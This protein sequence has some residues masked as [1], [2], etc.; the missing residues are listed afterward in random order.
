MPDPNTHHAGTAVGGQ[1]RQELLL[2]FTAVFFA[3]IASLQMELSLLREASF[4]LG[5]TAFT[6][7]FIISVFLGG[8]ALG[9]YAGSYLVRKIEGRARFLFVVSQ[10][11]NIA[12]ILFFVFTK[13]GILYGYHEK[14]VVL[15]YF[16]LVT[17]VPS[18]VAGMSFSLFLNMLYGKGE[19]FIAWV[20][21]VSTVGNVLSGFVHGLVLIPRY[22]MSATYVIAVIGSGLALLLVAQTRPPAKLAATVAI[23]GACLSIAWAPP[24]PEDTQEPILW[25]KDDVHGLVQVMDV[26]SDEESYDGGPVIDLRIDGRHQCATT[27][28]GVDWEFKS[29]ELGMQLLGKSARNVLNGGYCSGASVARLLDYPSIEEVTSIDMNKTVLE[30]SEIFFPEFHLKISA[31]DRSEVLIEEF[32]SYLKRQPDDEKYDLV[33]IDMAVKDPYFHGMFT[34][35][36]FVEIKK[37]LA[38]RGVVFWHKEDFVRTGGSV[39]PF[40]YTPLHVDYGFYY[41]TTFEL[42]PGLEGDFERYYPESES[43][44]IYADHEVYELEEGEIAPPLDNAS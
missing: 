17:I 31:D 26:S 36:F 18:I 33:L 35:E 11:L 13:G 32:R 40:T 7:S 29:V 38:D 23:A 12:V 5:S 28:Y 10:S 16:A 27:E 37:H 25:S 42:P 20:Y 14:R 24:Y 2:I 43:G 44:K 22:G 19:K 21:A 3:G 39:F 41:F 15:A 30:A 9:A 8:L 6:N 1:P 4:V 34:R